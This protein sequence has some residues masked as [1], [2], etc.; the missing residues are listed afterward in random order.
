MHDLNTIKRLNAQIVEDSI[1]HFQGQGRWVLARYDGLHI[2]SVESFS[3]STHAQAA[4]DIRPANAQQGERAVI[5]PPS[6][7]SQAPVPQR[8][9][10]EDRQQ[11]YSLEQL[12]A[13]GRTGEKTLGDYIARKEGSTGGV[14]VAQVNEN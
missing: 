8:D 3:E 14:P 12:A 2:S 10:S 4:L 13:L 7:V 11:P 1:R 5:F 6:A 9:Q